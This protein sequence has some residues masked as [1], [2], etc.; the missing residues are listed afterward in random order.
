MSISAIQLDFH[1]APFEISDKRKNRHALNLLI[2]IRV[3][4]YHVSESAGG[5]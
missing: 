1:I 3:V 2:F 4:V 5:S